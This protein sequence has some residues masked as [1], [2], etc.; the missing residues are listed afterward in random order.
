ME[1]V[2]NRPPTLPSP[3]VRSD[4]HRNLVGLAAN[5]S[6]SNLDGGHDVLESLLENFQRRHAS[7]FLDDSH[8]AVENLL[9]GD[10]LAIQHHS[11]DEPADEFRAVNGIRRKVLLRSKSFT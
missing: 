7:L 4:F 5:S 9:G 6:G 2:A 8:C 11:V 3:P 10:L 1:A